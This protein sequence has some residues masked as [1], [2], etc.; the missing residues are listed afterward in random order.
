MRVLEGLPELLDERQRLVDRERSAPQPVGQGAA[1][2]EVL[3]EVRRPGL[4]VGRVD[5]HDVR[6]VE[7]GQELD[8]APEAG[9]ELRVE[10]AL[11]PV[12]ADRLHRHAGPLRVLGLE[13]GPHAPLGQRADDA[14]RPDPVAGP[15]LLAPEPLPAQEPGQR[16]PRVAPAL[17]ADLVE[18]RAQRL[19]RH[20]AARVER[21][22]QR[23]VGGVVA[24]E[25]V[26]HRARVVGPGAE[27]YS[28]LSGA[29][30]RGQY[31]SGQG[32][33]FGQR[34]LVRSSSSPHWMQ[35]TN[36]ASEKR[37]A[38]SF[39]HTRCS[40]PG[41]GREARL[42]LGV[43]RRGP[44]LE[45]LGLEGPGDRPLGLHGPLAGGEGVGH[46]PLEAGLEEAGRPRRRRRGRPGAGSSC[47]GAWSV[48]RDGELEADAEAGAGRPPSSCR[49]CCRST[50]RR[51]LGGGGG[52]ELPEE[53]LDELP[54]SSTVQVSPRATGRAGR[55]ATVDPVPARVLA[56]PS[57]L[58]SK[59]PSGRCSSPAT[60]RPRPWS[61]VRSGFG[62][63]R[64]LARVECSK[65]PVEEL[66]LGS[67]GPP[68]RSA[69]RPSATSP[70]PTAVPRSL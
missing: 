34:R 32:C 39:S 5:A 40:V 2:E 7:P 50:L 12:R 21:A 29:P 44:P 17:G 67:C 70:S 20:L 23:R 14:V 49:G 26:G 57:L 55:R 69:A 4:Q 48:L 47:P 45:G 66:R 54:P 31:C 11:E 52:D 3:D 6:V 28:A 9:Q 27:R 68:R 33:P 62:S 22:G 36:S 13:D 18:G 42:A 58:S 46:G 35:R 8:L 64:P 38:A 30:S 59:G 25:G 19:E 10:P 60:R 15:G 51:A 37:W 63:C 16:Q 53:R 61:D 65:G 1:R 24:R 56:R 43:G 41:R